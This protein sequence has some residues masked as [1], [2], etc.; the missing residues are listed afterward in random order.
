MNIKTA[1]LI[2]KFA[3][4]AKIEYKHAKNVFERSTEAEQ[5]DILKG[6]KQEFKQ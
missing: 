4:K 2:R 3:K 1:K 6:L 5:K